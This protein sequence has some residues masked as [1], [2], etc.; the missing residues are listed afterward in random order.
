MRNGLLLLIMV[1]LLSAPAGASAQLGDP[2]G[3][4]IQVGRSDSL[5][6]VGSGPAHAP[7]L[8]VG[9][10]VHFADASGRWHSFRI[11]KRAEAV[12]LARL[13]DGGGLVAWNQGYALLVRSWTRDG[14]LAPPREVMSLGDSGWELAH[15]DAGTV[16]LATAGDWL[17]VAVRDPGGDFG[18]PE[19]FARASGEHLSA[20]FKAIA[21]DTISIS[22]DRKRFVRAGRGARFVAAPPQPA[23]PAVL[24]TDASK[25]VRVGPAVRKIC[26]V[27]CDPPR[28]FTWADGTARL[29]YRNFFQWYIARPGND[30]TFDGAVVATEI[31][32]EP[33]W[34][35]QPGVIAFTRDTFPGLALSPFGIAP[36]RSPSLGI[37]S[38]FVRDGALVVLAFCSTTCRLSGVGPGVSSSPLAKPL[39]KRAL[40]P[41]QLAIISR[42][43]PRGKTVQLTFKLRDVKGRVTRHVRTLR[44]GTRQ[45]DGA[46]EW[47]ASGP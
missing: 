15:D 6:A 38:A 29:V 14:A 43:E 4:P 18:A 40:E 12:R 46:R 3:L 2:V 45:V 10:R 26:T 42:R 31:G 37:K 32:G 1:A 28:L 17:Q 44:R 23:D 25:S 24:I 36:E 39:G 33:L 13:E 35:E 21:G 47:V 16:V 8:V 19:D 5:L 7:A 27:E 34:T 11:A 20:G 41:Y 30:G 9:G 22:W